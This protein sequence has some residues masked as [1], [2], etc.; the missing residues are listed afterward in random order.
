[1]VVV[2]YGL[3]HCWLS[4]N[5]ELHR[6]DQFEGRNLLSKVAFRNHPKFLCTTH[7]VKSLICFPL[8]VSTRS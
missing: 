8:F 6:I 1:M 5:E 7:F 4:E 2:A 3:Q